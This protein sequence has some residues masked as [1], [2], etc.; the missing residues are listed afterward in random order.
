M[1][2]MLGGDMGRA[3]EFFGTPGGQRGKLL[4]SDYFCASC[5]PSARR[6]EK[7]FDR[8]T[9]GIAKATGRDAEQRLKRGA[10][11][12]AANLK[13]RHPNYFWKET[14]RMNRFRRCVLL[15]VFAVVSCGAARAQDGEYV[16]NSPRSRPRARPG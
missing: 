15:F 9:A 2:K 14:A 3:G 12:K 5:W 6:T 4:L 16:V 8:L 13:N 1:P 10:D 11:Q 7:L